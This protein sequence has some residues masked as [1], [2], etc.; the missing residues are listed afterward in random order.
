MRKRPTSL[1][2]RILLQ[3]ILAVILFTGLFAVVFLGSDI[4]PRMEENAYSLLSQR[5]KSRASFLSNAMAQRWT[6]F[7][8]SKKNILETVEGML[9]AKGLT[10]SDVRSNAP[11]NEE[12]IGAIAPELTTMLRRNAVTGAFVVLDGAGV[13]NRPAQEVRAGLYI[14]D[15]DPE[16]SASYS[17]TGSDLLMER[18]LSSISKALRIPLDSYWSAGFH[19]SQDGTLPNEQFFFQPFRAALKGTAMESGLYGYWSP[20]FSLSGNDGQVITYSIPLIA[21]DG[22]V[23]GVMGIDLTETYLLSMMNYSDLWPNKKGSYCLGITEDGG[24]TFKQVAISGISYR[25]FFSQGGVIKSGGAAYGKIIRLDGQNGK[26]NALASVE[27][28]QLYNANTPFSNQ[29]WVLMGIVEKDVLLSFSSQ[30]LQL[31]YLALFLAMLLGLIGAV[32]ASRL[33]T[34]PIILLAAEVKTSNPEQAIALKKLNITEIDQLTASIEDLSSAVAESAS[35]ISKI[36]A[37]TGARIGVFEHLRDSSTVFLS[38]SLFDLMGW[39]PCEGEYGYMEAG[40]FN[41]R[42]RELELNREEG[43]QDIYPIFVGGEKR[44]V[45]VQSVQEESDILGIVMDVTRE[46]LEKQ[47]MAYERDYDVLTDL[48]NRRGFVEHCGRLL[49]NPGEAKVCALAMWDMDNLKYI[50][51]TY[52]HNVGDEYIQAFAQ[53]LRGRGQDRIMAARRSGDEFYALVYGYN[54]KAEALQV[55]REICREIDNTTIS[56]PSGLPYRLRASCGVAWYPSDATILEDLVRYA[57]FAMYQAKHNRKGELEEFNRL[58][59]EGNDVL[60]SG[61]EALNNLIEQALIDYAM[62]PI[63]CVKTGKVYG[64]EMLM[65]PRS[66]DFPGPRDVLRMAHSHEQLSRVERLTWFAAMQTFV[67]CIQIGTIPPDSR[68]FI[69]TIPNCSMSGADLASFEEQFG[70]HLKQMVLEIPQQ[71]CPSSEGFLQDKLQTASRWGAAA[72]IDD[73]GVNDTGETML[74]TLSPQMVKIGMSVIRGIESDHE[75]RQMLCAIIGFCRE[76]GIEVVAEGVET[77]EEMEALVSCGVD[78]LQGYYISLPS[79]PPLIPGREILSQV[80]EAQENF[81]YESVTIP[82]KIVTYS[83]IPK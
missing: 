2:R 65:R 73:Y 3:F 20:S 28:L 62:Q 79:M 17:L 27:N 12:L 34:R 39:P 81:C 49:L 47:Q 41:R 19:F 44:W 32:A 1:F 77:R 78:Y 36:I 72:A 59:Y 76:R 66:R 38:R 68:V 67:N 51:D 4:L 43:E 45:Q 52:G 8:M 33:I 18:G 15:L 69:H 6:N 29:Q 48:Y 61:Q 5:T 60:L 83:D 16:S 30:V 63:L 75:R 22:T 54:N 26:G 70:P 13:P 42:L 82:R 80:K 64:Y 14:R 57:D 25:R 53:C 11:L 55:V 46:V 24:N 23:F 21:S 35:K 40:D 31:I 71:G 7:E 74:S 58:L 56:L 37:M 50:N 9:S 10:W